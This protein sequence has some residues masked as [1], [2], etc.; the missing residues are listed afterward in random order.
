MIAEFINILKKRIKLSDESVKKIITAYK[1]N[2][3]NLIEAVLKTRII[4]EKDILEALSILYSIPFI[5]TLVT[6]DAKNDWI[7]RVSKNFLKLFYVVPIIKRKKS[8]IVI[9]DPSRLSHIHDLA[10]LVD[11]KK[12]Q[13]VLGPKN[14]ILSSI[15]T[16]YEKRDENTQKIVD[17]IEDNESVFLQEMELIADLL[18]VTNDAPVI[19][20][21]NHMISQAVK[22]GA[23]DIHFEPFRDIINIRY[24][25]DGI[26]YNILQPPKIAQASIISRI[27][28][29]AQMDIA[30]KRAPQDGRAQVR[31]GEYEIDIRIS[32]V[33]TNYGERVVMR[34]LNK[35]GYFLKLS[36]L[37]L[38]KKNNS[39]LNRII[40]QNSGVVLVTGPT[41]CGKTTTLYA[42]LSEINI[43]DKNIITIEDPVEYNIQGIGQIQVNPKAGV[44]FAKGLRSIV[45]QDPDIILV[46]EIRDLETAQIVI[47]S[48]L[49][50]HLVFSTLHT[51]DAAGAIIRLADLGIESYLISSSVNTIIAQRLVRKLCNNCKQQVSLNLDDIVNLG[52]LNKQL[53]GKKIF[54]SKGCSNCFNTGYSGREAIF[55]I[56]VLNDE[57]K[58]LVSKT[59]DGNI[60]KKAAQKMGMITLRQDGVQ[61]VLKGITSIKEV[62]RVTQT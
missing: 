30:E 38:S 18:D 47:Q 31:L 27:K 45:R 17:E 6:E 39:I 11:I 5:E 33:P 34:L 1:K 50:G 14:L 48:A 44:T 16:L 4:S 24:R 58:S 60:L 20:L 2:K 23:S 35:S 61:K 43:P 53:N 26:L 40:R 54:K 15:N 42:G 62:F 8:L 37:G 21:V 19:R 56:M 28:V 3:T 13:L 59:T 52:I 7:D 51:N 9:N 49:T 12:Y 29:M 41:G 46:G 36:Q 57:L 55:E 22:A 32:T 10:R 25:I